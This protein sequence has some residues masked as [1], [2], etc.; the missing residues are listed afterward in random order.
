[1]KNFIVLLVILSSFIF[2]AT[3]SSLEKEN[4]NNTLTLLSNKDSTVVNKLLVSSDSVYGEYIS[5][6]YK[7][8]YKLKVTGEDRIGVFII[9]EIY[10]KDYPIIKQLNMQEGFIILINGRASE[11]VIF[12][13]NFDIG[14]GDDIDDVDN[15]AL[16]KAQITKINFYEPITS[17]FNSIN[18][19]ESVYDYD[20]YVFS[21]VD[22]SEITIDFTESD[23]L[24][25]A[26]I[27][28]FSREKIL[29]KH[30]LHGD[31]VSRSIK[32]GFYKLKLRSFGK[33]STLGKVFPY[34]FKMSCVNSSGD[35]CKSIDDDTPNNFFEAPLIK[36]GEKLTKKIDYIGDLDYF[37]FNIPKD[38]MYDISVSENSIITSLYNSK[39]KSLNANC[40]LN[41]NGVGNNC[42][43]YLYKGS[44]Y[45]IFQN[46]TNSESDLPKYT[47]SLKCDKN[48]DSECS[49][50]VDIDNGEVQFPLK[51]DEWTVTMGSP[52]HKN[53]SY[54]DDTFSLDLNLNNNEDKGKPV[55]PI[56]AGKIDSYSKDWGA[57]IIEHTNLDYQ[58]S[59][60]MHM[61]D[62][63]KALQVKGTEVTKETM[64]G[65]ISDTGLT[66]SNR[67]HLHFTV[68][69]KTREEGIDI[70][71]KFPSLWTDNI[72]VWY[73][74][75]D[76]EY[77][78]RVIYNKGY[79]NPWWKLGTLPCTT[80]PD[81]GC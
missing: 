73:S 65:Q 48:F 42:H 58:Y 52:C 24:A 18:I 22:D 55:Y 44:Y 80:H 62:I 78:K 76:T 38:N 1:M 20:E 64:L 31:K 59:L 19:E 39:E 49:N 45:L 30:L 81:D 36:E 40:R 50:M 72:K 13:G 46:S 8:I 4:I 12:S 63:P 34:T 70:A 29:S 6:N 56:L 27:T 9:K 69:G 10:N 66:G 60:Y 15:L 3:L 14:G 74:Q 26:Y 68:Y 75:C 67:D 51:A 79:S 25:Y 16:D 54:K 47:F 7:Y 43:N 37:R 5:S 21:V 71:N 23:N 32:K 53:F 77:E 41:D 57:L 2:S 33:I 17:N 35:I 61:T 11:K 28:S